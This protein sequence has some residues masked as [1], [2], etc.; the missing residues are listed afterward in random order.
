MVLNEASSELEAHDDEFN[1]RLP[2]IPDGRCSVCP[3]SVAGDTICW[4][5]RTIYSEQD[6]KTV[7]QAPPFLTREDLCQCT[8]VPVSIQDHVPL[9]ESY[10]SNLTDFRSVYYAVINRTTG[11]IS[12]SRTGRVSTPQ[13]ARKYKYSPIEQDRKIRLA[14]LHPGETADPIRCTPFRASLDNLPPFEAV[15][16]TWAD[17]TGD[18]SVCKTILCGRSQPLGVTA[19]RETHCAACDFLML[20]AS[21]GS[22]LSTSTRGTLGS[23]TTRFIGCPRYFPKLSESWS[24][25]VKRIKASLLFSNSLPR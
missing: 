24:I 7:S 11:D 15:S 18:G 10:G 4:T 8:I 17:A 22:M 14:V 6:H 25:W 23:A 5:C 19:N 9:C 16:Y 2:V 1:L 20:N 12:A 21:F 13:P 3:R